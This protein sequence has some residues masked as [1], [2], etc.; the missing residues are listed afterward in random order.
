[1]NLVDICKKL[2]LTTIADQALTLCEQADRQRTP[3]LEFLSELLLLEYEERLIKKANRRIKEARFPRI[4]TF[5]SFSF[6][7]AAHLPE[8]LL[9]SL[10][11]G[12]YIKKFE[13]IILL[14]EP[15]SGKTHLACALGYAAANQGVTVRFTTASELA[16]QLVEA[17]DNR[18][19]IRITQRYQ[20]YQLL[21]L[22]ELGYL[23]LSKID[24][25]LLFQVL[26][27]RHEK[28]STIITT[29][30]PFGEWTLVFQDHRLCK[31]L[32][33]R[34]TYRSHII[35]TGERSIRFEET[36]VKFNSNKQEDKFN[37]NND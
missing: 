10:A 26:S 4:K 11:H 6:N 30:L 5:D 12:E 15:G 35:D 31:A 36:M 18:E 13:S 28:S 9:R 16:N 20:N 32:L 27:Q 2:H 25:E 23:P 33:D 3:Y 14:G 37:I 22:D 19:L 21:I 34:V 8:S 17:R 24:A 7:R 29:N 1:M